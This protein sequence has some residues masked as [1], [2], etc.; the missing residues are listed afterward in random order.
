MTLN[1]FSLM[2]NPELLVPPHSSGWSWTE[3]W[4][5]SRSPR[6]WTGSRGPDSWESPPW[7]PEEETENEKTRLISVS[8][9]W[10]SVCE[11]ECTLLYRA[12]ISEQADFL[13]ESSECSSSS[14]SIIPSITASFQENGTYSGEEHQC[15]PDK[16]MMITILK[17]NDYSGKSSIEK[18]S[19]SRL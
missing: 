17:K 4:T 6:C 3:T 10:T 7:R 2:T 11:N 9:A 19:Y 8:T 1:Y 16:S 15:Q 14:S 5:R 13:K 12:V 18:P